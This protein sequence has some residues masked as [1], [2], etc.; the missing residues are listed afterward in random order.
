MGV[1]RWLADRLGAGQAFGSGGPGR[2]L[3]AHD[4]PAI[5][6]HWQDTH[7]LPL[8]HEVGVADADTLFG[9]YL[10]DSVTRTGGSDRAPRL[11]SLGAGDCQLEL[12]LAKAFVKGGLREFTI[13]CVEP[14]PLLRSRG[15]ATAL[16]QGLDRHVVGVAAD[17][18]TWR[19]KHRYD[20]V[21]ANDSLHQVVRLER[22]LDDVH[23]SMAEGA[24]FVARARIGRNGH[25]RWPEA[26]A[27]VHRFW[28]E[29]PVGHRWNHRLRRSEQ[30]FTDWDSS[31]VGDDGVRAQDVLPALLQRFS[32]PVFAGF[33]NVVDPFVGTAF[34]PNFVPGNAWDRDFIEQ[35]HLRDE[36]LLANGTL[37]PTHMFAVMARDAE[38]VRCHAHGLAPEQCV[39]QR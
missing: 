7:V 30:T 25:R 33:G 1:M 6:H 28:Q 21:L 13:D 20:G 22:L 18:N 29:L 16:A 2:Q 4:V 32:L 23:K 38:P 12:R 3:V 5:F 27:E 9:H 37:T 24:W 14:N 31:R 34:G 36:E 35:V 8:L 15:R 11:L 26:L 19:S 17:C 39:R 10:R